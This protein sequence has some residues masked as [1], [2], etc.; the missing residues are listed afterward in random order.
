MCR[1]TYDNVSAFHVNSISTSTEQDKFLIAD[2]L[3]ISIW[4]VHDS[5]QA[6]EVVDLK[7]PRLDESC[8][9][10][11]YAAYTQ[12]DSSTFIYGTSSGLV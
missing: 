11:T 2:D 5:S 7:P 8:E 1:R 9:V 10:I 6:I 3:K 4:S 12:D